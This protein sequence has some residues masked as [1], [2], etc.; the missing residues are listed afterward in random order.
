[1]EAA[2]RVAERARQGQ[3]VVL[4]STTWPGTTQEVIVPLLRAQGLEPGEDV[5]VAFSP[6]RVDPGCPGHDLRRTPKVVGGVTARCAA[7]ARALYERT[8]ERVVEVGSAT[9]AEMV[10]LLENTFRSVNI[11]LANEMAVLCRAMGLDVWEVVEAA[12]TKPYGFMSFR[13]GPGTGG[14]CIPVDPLYLAWKARRH[15]VPARLAELAAE[16]NEAMPAHVVRVLEEA[17]QERGRPLSGAR[18]LVAGVAYK[19]DVADV[20]ESPGLALLRL[21]RRRG[22]RVAFHDSL[23]PRVVVEGETLTGVALTPEEAGDLD[24][25]VIATVHSADD[26][27]RLVRLAPLVVDTRNATATL[28]AE[29]PGLAERVRRL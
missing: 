11:A 23:V 25:A 26:V 10:K 3:L 16:I 19:S 29:A 6:E 4:E 9:T 18:V 21:L 15:G 22:A 17:L 27:G 24:A 7:A 2:R 8:C 1:V 12:A 5:A 13:P 20:R 28:L 14:H